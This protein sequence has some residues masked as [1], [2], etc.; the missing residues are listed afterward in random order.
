MILQKATN[1][2]R[3]FK[4]SL[5]HRSDAF[6]NQI[7]GVVH[8]GANLGQERQLYRIYDLS[9]VWIEPIP[10]VYNKLK[11]NITGYQNQRAFQALITDSD[12]KDYDFFVASNGGQSSSILKLKHHRDIWPFVQ[13]NSSINLR[14][15]TLATFYKNENI[16]PNLYQ[17]LVMDTQG[18]ELLVLLGSLPIL[19]NFKFIKTEVSTFESYEKCC[20]LSHI[21]SFMSDH[22]YEEYSR[23]KFADRAQGGSYFDIVY[24]RIG[25][26]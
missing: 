9:V 18:S 20:Q 23:F 4:H 17:A 25:S 16:D 21:E 14:G 24:K 10:E 22:G 13:Y 3:R 8:V 26:V 1:R 5:V 12:N 19:R 6:L 15:I 11:E 2:F 7:T